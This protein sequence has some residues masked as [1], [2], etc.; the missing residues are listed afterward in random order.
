MKCA[1]TKK[2]FSVVEVISP[3][4]AHFGRYNDMKETPDMLR[5]L[6]GRAVPVETYRSLSEAERQTCFP[7]GPLVDR[8]EPDFNERYESLRR[9]AVSN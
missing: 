6:R 8:N 5:W 3:C 2:G 1:L 7:I 9:R 4:P